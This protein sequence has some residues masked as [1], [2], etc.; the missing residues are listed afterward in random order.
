MNFILLR[1]KVKKPMSVANWSSKEV[2][3]FFIFN[4]ER[5]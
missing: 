1:K 2:K 4:F 5:K 3:I